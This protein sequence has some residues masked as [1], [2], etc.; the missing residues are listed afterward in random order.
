MHL[1]KTH[2]Y[3]NDFLLWPVTSAGDAPDARM[4]TLARS[5]CDRHWGV[6]ADG[7]IRV[8]PTADGAE[9]TLINADGSP[10]EVSGNGLRCV[11][12]WL[13]SER[14]L[15]TGARVVIQTAAGAKPL[16][17]VEHAN[18]RWTFQADM[19]KPQ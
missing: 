11:A 14:G 17:L 8:Q 19:G 3:G 6:G 12:A 4:S 18:G 1:I 7:F 10:A 9:T 15:A 2:A 5:L 16:T 13:A